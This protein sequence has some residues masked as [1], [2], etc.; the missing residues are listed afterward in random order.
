[1]GTDPSDDYYALLGDDYYALL[2]IDADADDEELRRAGRRLAL[3][4]HPDRAGPGATATF[5][6]ISA[7]YSVLSD[8]LARAE[9][10]RRRGARRSGARS[11]DAAAAPP[12]AAGTPRRAPSVM[13]SRLTGSLDALLA[14]GVARRAE[15]GTIELFLNAQE[16]ADGGMVSISMRVKVRCPA[17]DAD[18]AA[19]CARCGE[20]RTIDE[21]F[22]AW[23]AVRPGIADGALLAP[24]ALLPGM[25][26]PVAFRVRVRDAAL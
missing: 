22:S 15:G 12:A 19:S 24:S 18:D 3:R 26:R 23:L 6:T 20:R 21:L 5:Q 1:M 7:A 17:C 25:V 10:D 2:G 11:G 16:A 14:C 8:P 13:L 9:Y 4:L